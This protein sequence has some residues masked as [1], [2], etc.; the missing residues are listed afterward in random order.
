M[1]YRRFIRKDEPIIER[2]NQ[3]ELVFVV[4]EVERCG[5]LP[6]NFR[7]KI[8]AGIRPPS[9]GALIEDADRLSPT[10]VLT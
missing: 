10:S 8:E 6:G 1:K 9:L 7:A 3:Y 5:R 4:A 2:W